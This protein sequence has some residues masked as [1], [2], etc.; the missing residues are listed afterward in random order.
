MEL[1]AKSLFELKKSEAFRSKP[2]RDKVGIWTIGYGSTYYPNGMKVSEFDSPIT[3]A[4]ASK[5]MMDLF[6]K[7]FAPHIP[8]NVNQQ[9]FDALG[10]LIYNIGSSNF[11]MSTLKK[12][13]LANPN[14]PTI[15]DEFLKWNKGTI[16]G[17]KVVIPGLTIRRKR[18]AEWY[19]KKEMKFSAT[20]YKV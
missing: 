5:L 2:Y 10:Q 12:K 15:R 18:E 16:N 11:N 3:E 19:F 8:Q 13:V 17:Q 1:S 14:D 4:E 20:P 7:D 9:Q 6:K